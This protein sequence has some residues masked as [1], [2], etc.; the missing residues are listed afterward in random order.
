MAE[1]TTKR[2]SRKPVEYPE[3]ADDEAPPPVVEPMV[4]DVKKLE[5]ALSTPALRPA[6]PTD[7]AGTY[8][9][10]TMSDT[11]FSERLATLKRGRDRIAEIQRELMEVDVDYGLI[12][13]TPKPTLFKAGA[14]KLALIYGLAAEVKHEF[15]PGDGDVSPA[16]QY[17]ATVFLHLGSFDGPIVAVGHGTAN[18][19]EKRYRRE[20]QKTCPN[21]GKP[22]IIKSKPQ[23]GGGWYCFPKKEGCGMSFKADDPALT[24]QA[25]DAKGDSVGSWDLGNTLLKMA[26]KRA[27]VDAVLRATA[28]SS[29]FTQDVVE[30][31]VVDNQGQ[32]AGGAA[33]AVD[34][35]PDLGGLMTP[36]FEEMRRKE[37]ETEPE[38][39][40]A[41]LGEVQR[42]G[43]RPEVTGAQIEAARQLARSMKMTP[44]QVADEIAE[45]LGGG[46]DSTVVDDDK[47]KAGAQLLKFME[48][49][50]PDDMGKVITHLR[51]KSAAS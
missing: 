49:M 10:A 34:T 13:G 42:G 15:I 44:W 46:I 35:S 16:I 43:H 14:E 11:E 25:T 51:A 5:A 4:H 48:G 50:D 36:E 24:E 3:P 32:P 29:L 9:L 1:A 45:V 26:E 40:S 20:A 27:F 6:M 39:R 41:A 19:W 8:A 17:H 7:A 30:E 37:E 12:P 38:V 28:S 2:R 33:R 47:A 18:S 21:C 22:A 23:F 31:P